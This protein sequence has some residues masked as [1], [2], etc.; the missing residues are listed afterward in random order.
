MITDF[1]GFSMK[2]VKTIQSGLAFTLSIIAVLTHPS[3]AFAQNKTGNQTP[4]QSI[5]KAIEAKDALFAKLSGKLKEVLTTQ[6]PVAAIEVCSLEAKNM[7]QSVGKSLGLNI[8]RTAWKLRNSANQ[9]P[10]WAK[11]LLEKATEKPLFTPLPNHRTG[12]LFPIKL[13]AQ[14]LICHGE[15][16]FIPN[17]VQE[18]L[19]KRYPKDQATGFKVDELRGWFWVEVDDNDPAQ[20][21]PW[22]QYGEMHRV[23]GQKD[24]KGRV[25]L[26]E[27][28][29]QDHLYAVGAMKGLQGEVTILDSVPYVTAQDSQSK[30]CAASVTTDLQATLLMG[31]SVPAWQDTTFETTLG[32]DKWESHLEQTAR[33]NHLDT[34]SPIMFQ[35]RGRLEDTTVHV[36]NGACPIHAQLHGEELAPEEKPHQETFATIQG[37]IVGVFAK[38]SSGR[39]THPGTSV[40]AHLIYQSPETGERLTGHIEK[41]SIAK[42]STLSL[43]KLK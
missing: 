39:L 40:H 2:P 22:F 29:K 32:P 23:I 3:L 9:P 24:H 33:D 30:L 41:T 16:T 19:A 35:V 25:Q 26:G 37:T 31:A 14:C 6:G 8:G 7:T 20:T 42:G 4:P 21:S 12:A 27:L 36:I 11:P 34:A 17:N 1:N 10:Q 38:A 15:K 28:I 43:P 18:E 5:E 13:K